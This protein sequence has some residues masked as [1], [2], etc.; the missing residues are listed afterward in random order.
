MDRRRFLLASLAGALAVPFAAGAQQAVKV[1]RIGWLS[2]EGRPDPFVEGFREG[3]RGLG[4]VEGQN[5]VLELRYAPG[6]LAALR[7]ALTEMA[8]RVSPSS[9][10]VDRP[11]RPRRSR[12][13]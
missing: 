8:P 10:P 6:D 7:T 5:Y 9:S 3:L 2:T 13:E 1:H 12:R 4:Y 11:F